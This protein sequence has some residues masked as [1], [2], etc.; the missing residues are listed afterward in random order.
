MKLDFK[1]WIELQSASDC[2]I[3]MADFLY[4]KITL[5][6]EAVSAAC[7]ADADEIDRLCHRVRRLTKLWRQHEAALVASRKLLPKRTGNVVALCTP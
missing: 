4:G 2:T 6:K 3:T 1:A 5:A 7:S